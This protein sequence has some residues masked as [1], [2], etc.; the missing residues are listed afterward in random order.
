MDDEKLLA[1][2]M[3]MIKKCVGREITNQEH[4]NFKEDIE[5]D[6]FLKLYRASFFEKYSLDDESQ[7]KIAFSYIRRTAKSCYLDYLLR[8]NLIRAST[9]KERE[10][11]G[12]RYK[13]IG[14]AEDI[15]EHEDLVNNT[16][17]TGENIHLARL[18]YKTIKDCFDTAI[19]TIRDLTRKTFLTDAFW[20]L[21]QCDIPIKELA[22][23]VGFDNSN[24]TQ[25]FNRFVEKVSLCTE[26]NGIF[27]NNINEQVEFLSQVLEAAEVTQ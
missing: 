20:S 11:F 5:Q 9:Q 12:D 2:F 23:V 6:V 24:P 16:Y 26:P 8:T 13:N 7:E 18:A 27:I 19:E 4:Y 14:F 3:A 15:S 10:E 25:T 17:V 1:R 22:S 21:N